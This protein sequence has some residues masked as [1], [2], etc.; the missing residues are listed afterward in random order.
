MNLCHQVVGQ[1][2]RESKVVVDK[3]LVKPANA[4]V[5]GVIAIQVAN[6]AAVFTVDPYRHTCQP[7]GQLD[8]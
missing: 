8:L 1:V 2:A 5:G 7:R 4:L 3:P 6:V